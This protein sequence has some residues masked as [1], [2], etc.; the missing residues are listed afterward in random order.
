MRGQ[1]SD[2]ILKSRL[3]RRL[4]NNMTDAEQRLWNVLRS[5]QLDGCK[6]R[7]QHPYYHC[8]LDF[9]CLERKV[10]VEVDGGQH[11]DSTTDAARDDFLRESGFTVLRFWNHEVLNRTEAVAEAIHRALGVHRAHHPHPD[12]PLEGE[13]EK[14]S[15]SDLSIKRR[16]SHPTPSLEGEGEKPPGSDLSVK[17]HKSHPTRPLEGEG[18]ESC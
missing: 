1:T 13:G 11:A 18:E 17:P 14:P 12:P 15:G 7:R 2:A 6:F 5:R 3:Q 8:I 10:V 4:R 16:H 9:V